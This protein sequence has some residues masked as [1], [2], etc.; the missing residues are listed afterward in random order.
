MTN[1]DLEAK[2][3]TLHG[4]LAQGQFLESMDA[5]LADDVVLQEGDQQPKVGK[6]HCMALEAELLE[7]VAEFKGY[8]VSSVGSSD[9]KTYYESVMEFV[10]KDGTEVRMQQCVVDTWKDGKIVHERFYHA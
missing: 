7:T 6:A 1:T 5:F 9:D 3:A 10:Q 2:L 8:S 4:M